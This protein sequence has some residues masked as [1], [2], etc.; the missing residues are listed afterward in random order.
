[1]RCVKT[2]DFA[3]STVSCYATQNTLTYTIEHYFIKMIREC[4][5]F[6]CQT[7]SSGTRNIYSECEIFTIPVYDTS[8]I[9][10]EDESDPH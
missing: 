3:H 9:A 6:L 1:M 8:R 4:C 2:A 7:I 5:S 10:A